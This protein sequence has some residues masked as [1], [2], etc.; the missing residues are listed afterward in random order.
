[1]QMKNWLPL[2][3]INENRNDNDNDKIKFLSFIIQLEV[4]K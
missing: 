1:M 3:Y 2:R 4:K